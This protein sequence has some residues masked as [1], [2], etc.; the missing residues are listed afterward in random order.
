MKKIRYCI[1]LYMIIC[2]TL[3]IS[4][5]W[6]NQDYFNQLSN[7]NIYVFQICQVFS[8]LVLYFAGYVFLTAVQE[9]LSDTWVLLLAF[10]CGIA[11]WVFA[12]MALLMTDIVYYQYRVYLLM[13]VGTG[14]MLMIR[15]IMKLPRLQKKLPSYKTV[16]IVLGM[17]LLVSTGWNYA[18]MNYDSYLYFANYGKTLTLFQEWKAF[19]TGNAYVLTNIGQFLPL[20][21]SYAAFWGYEYSLP[22]QSFLMMNTL[23]A[24]SVY[25][26]QYSET[27]LGKRKSAFFTI[28]Y[29]IAVVS[30]TPLLIY[31]NWLL[32]N[33]FLMVYLFIAVL[34][35]DK[36]EK[37]LSF[38][39]GIIIT[40]AS[41][42]VTL[43]RKDG[44]IIVCFLFV[45]ISCKKIC[46]R[47]KLLLMFLPSAAIQLYYIYLIRNVIGAVTRTAAGTSI[48]NKKFIALTVAGIAGTILFIFFLES[49]IEKVFKKRI[50]A[51]LLGLMFLA[52]ICAI[53]LKPVTSIDH[54]DAI[55]RVLLG[56]SYGY[57][58]FA[59]GILCIIIL[60]SS[61]KLDFHKFFI[62]GYCIL[63]FLIY[64]N[65]GNTEQGIDNS[66]MRMFYQVIPIFYY[67]AGRKWIELQGAVNGKVD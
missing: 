35:C 38:D 33:A 32:S 48:L 15:K 52:A 18:I 6:L 4:S 10:P 24:L 17:A 62:I 3:F 5:I 22:I 56:S 67:Y 1:L 13:A 55:I 60:L 51:I 49:I 26:Y 40:G 42:A 30:C 16:F 43:L 12:S 2:S 36:V 58:V 11:L 19:N 29:G 54:I 47:E 23:A 44:I 21:N 66:G 25:I 9:L 37:R 41:L 34:I 31:S 20:V 57:T 28:Y 7:Q 14:I 39:Y 46:S 45:C 59:W 61:S 27:K 65:K 64:W 8:V 50:Y 63:T 53:M